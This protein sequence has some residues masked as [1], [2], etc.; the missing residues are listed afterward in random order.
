MLA[1]PSFRQ[2][3]L[4]AW[5]IV[6]G[7]VCATA[8]LAVVMPRDWHVATHAWLGLGDFPSE[9]IVEYLARGMSAIC[10]FYGLL[11]VMLA[12]DVRRY[13]VLIARQAVALLAIN[14]V[15]TWILWQRGMPRWWL[16]AD[17]LSV[18]VF[19]GGVLWLARWPEGDAAS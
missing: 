6:G 19:C 14:L 15:A 9:P 2:R 16:L 4:S 3:L 5:L 12:S 1:T 8:L 7:I 13:R 17:V 10:G 11:L 18:A